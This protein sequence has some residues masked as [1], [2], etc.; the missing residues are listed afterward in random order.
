RGRDVGD[1]AVGD[2]EED[3]I[4]I[5]VAQRDAPLRE[6]R[7]EG[8]PDAPARADDVNALDHWSRSSPRRVPGRIESTPQ[9]M[10]G[11]CPRTWRDQPILAAIRCSSAT[12]TSGQSSSITAYQAESRRSPPRTSMCLRWMPS[13]WDGSAARAARAR[14][15]VASVL[16]STR[17]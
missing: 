10:S 2:A 13:N 8:R 5:L 9:A 14:S 4:G 1:R 6:A 15:F 16:N 17:R 7:G 12:F 3:E 11:D